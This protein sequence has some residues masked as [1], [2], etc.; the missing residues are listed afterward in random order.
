[1][2]NGFTERMEDLQ[3]NTG[4]RSSFDCNTKFTCLSLVS[5]V[6]PLTAK[7]RYSASRLLIHDPFCDNLPHGRLA[8]RKAR[9]LAHVF[10]SIRNTRK[11]LADNLYARRQ[12]LRSNEEAVKSHLCIGGLTASYFADKLH[13]IKNV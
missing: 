13:Q 7:R 3:H 5:E 2:Y 6:R 8:F 11:R 1:M 4:K 12:L 9:V 10:L